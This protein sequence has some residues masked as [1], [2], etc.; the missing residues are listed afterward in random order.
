MM[1]FNPTYHKGI[2]FTTY[3]YCQQLGAIRPGFTIQPKD[4]IT[5]GTTVA[6]VG[7]SAALARLEI[8]E[9]G[10][11]RNYNPAYLLALESYALAVSGLVTSLNGKTNNAADALT[12]LASIGGMTAAIYNPFNLE[13]G[14]LLPPVTP[15]FPPAPTPAPPPQHADWM[16][17]NQKVI[18]PRRL[19]DLVLPGTHDSATCD[20]NLSSPI[21][22]NADLKKLVALQYVPYLA[23]VA[24]SMMARWARNQAFDIAT[25]LAAGIRYLD[26]R[27]AEMNGEYWTVHSMLGTRLANMLREVAQ[28]LA[29]HPKEV[30]ILDFN[31]FYSITD[32]DQLARL[33]LI[34][35]GSAVA[36]ANAFTP[37]STLDQF[38]SAGR[39]A[40]VLFDND[41]VVAAH[42]A[43]WPGSQTAPGARIAS[44]WLQTTDLQALRTY[45]DQTLSS[46]SLDKLFVSQAILDA[47][48]AWIMGLIQYPH[49]LAEYAAAST[50]TMFD[51][52]RG[53][54]SRPLNIVI[55]DWFTVVPDY[56]E[57]LIAMTMH[58]TLSHC[59]IDVDDQ[60]GGADTRSFGFDTTGDAGGCTVSA[61]MP[62]SGPMAM[63]MEPG[64]GQQTLPDYSASRVKPS[65]RMVLTTLRT[66]EHAFVAYNGVL[67][68]EHSLQ[69]T[70]AIVAV[71]P[72]AATPPGNM[73]VSG[74]SDHAEFLVDDQ[75]GGADNRNFV[76]DTVRQ[77][78]GVKVTITYPGSG[79]LA[80]T[81]T[82]GRPVQ[83]IP[84]QDAARVKPSGTLTLTWSAEP[85]T[86]FRLVSFTGTLHTDHSVTLTDVGIAIL[87]SM[88]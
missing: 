52:F 9:M 25:Q 46:R 38:W 72:P 2:C 61:S 3:L 86:E 76:F 43:L 85:A 81:L 53:W 18:G 68:T 17:A 80:V 49:N 35:L 34:E 59:R 29:A 62:G 54:T 63:R 1:A 20:I 27:V 30:V 47:S 87:D 7:V 24:T 36:P 37:Q 84:A 73:S 64:A 51:W 50:P 79:P 12:V 78:D 69:T 5:L 22:P 40:V 56:V 11:D 48:N 39:Q 23:P 77:G 31:H 71:V 14:P 19:C 16:G 60:G 74:Y 10:A 8:H 55:I 28:F 45:L 66:G 32:W 42:P 44:P 4:L 21:D 6:Q 33:I 58:G 67:H 70:N 75:G 15:D 88:A 41:Q 57:T 13:L 65:G 83:A 26:L 82:K